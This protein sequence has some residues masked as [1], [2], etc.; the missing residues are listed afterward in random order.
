[1]TGLLPRAAVFGHGCVER[2]KVPLS[3]IEM[4]EIACRDR[5]HV[6]R[7]AIRPIFLKQRFDQRQ[8]A[9]KVVRL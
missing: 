7:V 2:R 4:L 9:R 8:S 1:M 5:R 3:L 6:K